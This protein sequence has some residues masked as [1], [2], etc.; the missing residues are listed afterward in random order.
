VAITHAVDHDHRWVSATADGRIT[1]SDVDRHL[2][3]EHADGG[4]GYPELVDATSAAIDLSTDDI[5]ALVSRVRK[6]AQT[7]AMGPTAVLV[8]S[9]V[10]YGVMRMVE[11]L[12]EPHA[13]VRPF[14]D[15][16]EAEAWLAI[17]PP[18]PPATGR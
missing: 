11:M 7:E 15:R 18:H 10:D 6:L 17:T 5:H 8:G 16:A 2:T 3:A 1:Y 4:L 12:A 13:A 9:D 14:R